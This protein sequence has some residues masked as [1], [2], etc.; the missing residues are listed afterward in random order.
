MR[1]AGVDLVVERDAS[2]AVIRVAGELDLAA[3]SQLREWLSRLAGG[4]VVVDLSEVS[5]IDSSALGVLVAAHNKNGALRLRG[6]QRG[7]MRVLQITGLDQLFAL[8]G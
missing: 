4:A 3:C 1:Q 7:P 8:D 6:L 5:F 2:T